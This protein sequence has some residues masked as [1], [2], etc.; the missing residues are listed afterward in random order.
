MRRSAAQAVLTCAREKWPR[1]L[2]KRLSRKR[3]CKA[4]PYAGGGTRI[5]HTLNRQ[6]IKM[7]DKQKQVFADE[8]TTHEVTFFKH[9]RKV[10][11]ARRRYRY[12]CSIKRS[13]YSLGDLREL[14]A[15]PQNAIWSL[16]GTGG[17]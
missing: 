16:L 1:F 5:K 17:L 13:I 14:L 11:A 6:A 2:G 7:Y 3:R 9:H 12:N 4:I 15:A 10:A 8:C